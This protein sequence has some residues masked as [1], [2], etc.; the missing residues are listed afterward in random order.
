[1]CP[2]AREICLEW[3]K[4]KNSLNT[5]DEFENIFTLLKLRTYGFQGT[6]SIQ[7]WEKILATPLSAKDRRAGRVKIQEEPQVGEKST[8]RLQNGQLPTQEGRTRGRTRSPTERPPGGR[9]PSPAR[10]GRAQTGPQRAVAS[11]SPPAGSKNPARKTRLTGICSPVAVV[12]VSSGPSRNGLASHCGVEHVSSA[13]PLG[14]MSPRGASAH[15]H[16]GCLCR[17]VCR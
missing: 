7:K 11:W 4:K 1:M 2:W 14:A 13:I 8:T 3:C 16:P 15:G 6:P 12:S 10:R 9:E 5:K 17:S